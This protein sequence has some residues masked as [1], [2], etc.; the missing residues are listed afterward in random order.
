MLCGGYFDV[1]VTSGLDQDMLRKIR[2]VC[3]VDALGNMISVDKENPSFRE[4]ILTAFYSLPEEIDA[5]HEDGDGD[6][7][8]NGQSSSSSSSSS[9]SKRTS[10][11]MRNQPAASQ[12]DLLTLPYITLPFTP[13][14]S[15]S[16]LH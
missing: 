5:E 4:P 6:G 11:R 9:S 15:L 1:G 12:V 10:K 3:L 7:N 16:S 8:G 14:Q 13:L 2:C